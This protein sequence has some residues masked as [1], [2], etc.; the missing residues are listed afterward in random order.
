[1]AEENMNGKNVPYIGILGYKDM[2]ENMP[3][4]LQS[5]VCVLDFS[6]A[7]GKYG[8]RRLVE[9]FNGSLTS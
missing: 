9:K 4:G 1:M 7:F 3:E 2:I 6:K 5:D 8:H